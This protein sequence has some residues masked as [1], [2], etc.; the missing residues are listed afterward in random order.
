MTDEQK[1]FIFVEFDEA[2]SPHY[3]VSMNGVTSAQLFIAS[4]L[5]QFQA[6]Q[7]FIEE[8]LEAEKQSLSKPTEGILKP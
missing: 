1:P 7:T 6:N 5:L 3:K 8:Q 4:G 2:G